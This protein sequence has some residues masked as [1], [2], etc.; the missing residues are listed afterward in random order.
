MNAEDLGYT[1][2]VRLS[3]MIRQKQVSPVEVVG[4]LLERITALE[5]QINA[6]VYLAADQAMAAARSSE[7]A[8]MKGGA[9]GPLHGVPVTIKDLAVTGDMPTQFGSLS[10]AGHQP[11]EDTPLVSRL[12]D[13]GAIVLGKTTTSEF[14][15]K[16]VSQSP[17]T[18]ITHNPCK[19]G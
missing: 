17:L 11:A 18:G 7:A 3:E 10:Q 16:G 13:A 19:H 9:L 15:W 14:G 1:P 4:A 12:K 5:P 8:L 6:F 2:A